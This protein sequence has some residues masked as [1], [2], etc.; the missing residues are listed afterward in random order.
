M[1]SKGSTTTNSAQSYTPNAVAPISYALQT[2]INASQTPYQNYNGELTAGLQ[3]QQ[4]AGMTGINQYANAAQPYI[5]NAQNYINQGAQ[6]PLQNVQQYM[7][8]YTQSVVD[9][10]QNQFNASNQTQQS[11]LLGNAAAQ[12]ALGGDRAAVAQADLA[13]QQNLAQN[14]VISGLYSTGFNNAVTAAQTQ[15]N[16]LFNAGYGTGSLGTAAQ[17]AGLQ[18]AAAQIQGGTLAQQTQ[19]AQDTANYNEFLRQAGYPFQTSQFLTQAT[20]G[21]APSLGGSGVGVSQTTPAQ[22]SLIGQLTGLGLTG[23]GLYN[24]LGGSKGSKGAT[25]G[26][27][28][29]TIGGSAAALGLN[30]GGA[31]N[32]FASGG[33]VSPGLG[34]LEYVL[35]MAKAIRDHLR[36]VPVTQPDGIIVPRAGFADGGSPDFDSDFGA[37]ATPPDA[38]PEN[39]ALALALA[40]KYD[41]VDPITLNAGVPLPRPRPDEAPANP[42]A[43][44]GPDDPSALPATAEPT[45]GLT[46]PGGL[47]TDA[48]QSPTNS[49]EWANTLRQAIAGV[50][51]YKPQTS[52][53]SP[54]VAA[55]LGMLASGSPFPG[56]AI[57]K[58]GLEGLTAVEKAQANQR[59]DATTQANLAAHKG[60]LAAHGLTAE[61]AAAHLVQQA[62][63][64]AATLAETAR[65]HDIT[66]LSPV[67][68]GTDNM[69]RDI[70][71]IR[72]PKS[73][74]VTPLDPTTGKPVE[75]SPPASNPN[76]TFID[77]ATGKPAPQTTAAAS[78]AD[79]IIPKNSQLVSSGVPYDYSTDAPYIE[80]GMD[81]PKPSPVAGKSTAAVQTDAEYYLQTGKLPPVAR[82]KNP[83]AVQMNNYRNAVQNYAASLAQSRGVTPEQT[84]DMWR[85]AP[86]MLRFIMGPDGRS[87][88]ALGTAFR[89]LDTVQQLGKAWAANDMQ[90]VN[91]LRAVISREFGSDAATNLEAAGRIVGP[92]IVK[93]LGVA[94]AGTEHDRNT[95]SA[96][97]S[98]TPSSAQLLGAADTVQ[99]LLAGQLEGKKRQA[100]NAGVSEERFKNLIGDRPYEVL[101]GADKSSPPKTGAPATPRAIPDTVRQNG[102]TYQKQQ[103]GS[104]KA[105]D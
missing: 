58:G 100:L 71:G 64:H 28:G 93:A 29:S 83:V 32:G 90:T 82:G 43:V 27:L 60:T 86:G 42:D 96:M 2:A 44:A 95:I 77:P 66:Q 59:A 20:A 41:P 13:K 70:Y 55:G 46:P 22:P 101:S 57:G 16:A 53:V 19:Q 81:V 56:V 54:L 67:K 105:I 51:D 84:A 49:S 1:G 38:T 62:Q 15:Q 11:Q 23:A 97:F 4:Q 79:G 63:Q 65:Q 7:N 21:L 80:K 104:Y 89:H 69:G 102:H 87:T 48:P 61:Q 74:Q 24:S 39:R 6:N 52:S 40:Q 30:R 103:D 3:P 72:D 8:P 17:N 14:P 26:G 37:F 92:E 35:P 85:T 47:P 31:V 33:Q 94:G 50:G 88:V 45:A 68:I 91:R 78:T 18:G 76:S 75:Q 12:G 9:A 36:A 10:T 5:Q 73:G 34:M 25:G 98:S 99:K